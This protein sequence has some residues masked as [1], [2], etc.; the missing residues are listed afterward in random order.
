MI[1]KRALFYSHLAQTSPAP[2]G[3]EVERAKGIYLY[4]SQGKAY[5]DLIAGISVSNV[6][7]GHPKVQEAV[8]NQIDLYA[9][10]M[11]YGEYIQ[12]PQVE[13]AQ[14]IT[15]LLPPQ[16]DNVYFVNSGSEANEGAMKLAKRYTGRGKLVYCK[17]AYHGSTQGTLSIIGDEKF[18]K[19]FEPLLPGTVEMHFNQEEDL[20]ML[21]EKG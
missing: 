2:M 9:H 21:L 10:L 8:K 12:G 18:K 4:D 16:L 3:L 19:P 14:L 6:G 1:S 20:G 15:S 5:I 7:H 11:V 17:N 13:L